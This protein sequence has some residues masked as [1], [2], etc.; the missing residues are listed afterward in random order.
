MVPGV[1]DIE[2][3]FEEGEFVLIVDERFLKK[4]AIGVSLY[5]SYT[6]RTL[7]RG[8]IVKNMHYVGDKLWSLIKTF[9]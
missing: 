9:F 5:D 6:I 2:G 1:V 8:K 3:D 7:K 4:L